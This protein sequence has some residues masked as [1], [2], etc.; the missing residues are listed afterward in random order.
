MKKGQS[1]STTALS[2][3]GLNEKALCDYVLNVA[4]GCSHGC[5][6]CY[7]PSTP[8]YRFDPGDKLEDAGID[9]PRAE[10]G[11]YV[12]YRDDL[13]DHLEDQLDSI[14]E[15]RTT[16]R[17]QGVVGIS[18]GTDAYMDE[19][20][21]ELATSAA[22]TLVEHGKPVRILTRNPRLADQLFGERLAALAER[23]E[24]TVGTSVPGFDDEKI[25]VLEPNAP[26]VSARLRDLESLDSRGIP[27]YV[28]M[29]PV[30]PAMGK[31]DLRETLETIVDHVDPTVIFTEPINRRG[32]NLEACAEAAEDAGYEHLAARLES[33]QN[34]QRWLEY[35]AVF[36]GSVQRLAEEDWFDSPI[37]LWPDEQ[38][39]KIVSDDMAEWLRA[40]KKRP[41]PETVGDGPA[42]TD[43]YPETLYDEP[44]RMEQADLDSFQEVA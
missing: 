17:G 24:L 33:I 34:E 5:R 20:A 15:W 26:P 37:H 11:E 31:A 7:V 2:E 12:L 44:T 30:Y 6:F 43:G 1:P 42:C 27:V 18:F 38:L 41:S 3:S 21:G 32:G 39:I 36:F 9:D 10:W 19:R 40:W 22:E 13:V 4:E 14:G 16:E 23:G 25:A 29:S 35:A 8:P 28:S